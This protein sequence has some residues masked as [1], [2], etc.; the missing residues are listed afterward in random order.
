MSEFGGVRTS[1]RG[2]VATGPDA[3]LSGIEVT[4]HHSML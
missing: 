2:T 3:Q 4:A 1:S